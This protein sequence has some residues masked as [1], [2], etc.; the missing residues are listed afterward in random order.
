MNNCLNSLKS[1]LIFY[2]KCNVAIICIK[3]FKDEV[4]KVLIIFIVF[5]KFIKCTIRYLWKL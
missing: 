4:V 1:F 3:I 5:E 2:Q